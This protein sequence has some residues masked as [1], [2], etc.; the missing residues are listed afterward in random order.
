MSESIGIIIT[1][2]GDFCKGAVDSLNM[3]IGRSENLES[4]SV[5]PTSSVQDVETEMEQKYLKLLD[6]CTEVLIF[7]DL[8]CGTPNNIA[9]KLLM[10]Y[11]N[12]TIFTGYNLA[13]LVELIN[14]RNCG[15]NH[16]SEL[17]ED[18]KDIFA[19]S[20]RILKKEG[21]EDGN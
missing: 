3:I 6:N 20:N 13:I 5:T 14:R 8:I 15:C 9:V 7:T 18:A 2:H 19:D 1:S 11:D 4:V 17:L 10:K 21:N 12:I 16:I